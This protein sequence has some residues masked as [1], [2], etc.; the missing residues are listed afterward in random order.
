VV[1]SRPSPK[2]T[3]ENT[4]TAERRSYA[5]LVGLSR[6][7]QI[8]ERLAEKPRRAQDLARDL[9]LKWTTAH[10][11]LT[12]LRKEGYVKRDDSTGLYHVGARLYYIGSSYTTNLPILQAARVYLKTA[13]DT[14]SA[15]AQLVER[16]G[17]T[18]IVLMVSEPRSPYI[19]K[20][21]IG[22]H[23]P[24]HCGSKGQ[25]LLAF[26][27]HD[28]IEDYLSR[29]LELLTP[30]SI[31]EPARL[32]E[33]LQIIRNQDYAVT[34]RDVQLVTGSVAAPVRD[35]RGLVLAS[36]CL[37]TNLVDLEQNEAKLLDVVLDTARSIS[38]LMGWQPGGH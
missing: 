22:H 28:F 6:A 35:S 36:A 19:P 11:T 3:N 31:I 14:T 23:F 8:L 24:L 1:L 15:T 13:A 29:P 20:T 37:I 12:Y 34:K 18:T 33:I 2:P 21:D 10:R 38:Q 4:S 25:V 16:Y 7:M 5:Q 32:R 27:G 26:A 9:G 30:Y 17:Q